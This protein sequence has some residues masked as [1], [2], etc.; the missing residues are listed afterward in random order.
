MFLLLD[1]LLLYI[2]P[3]VSDLCH[4]TGTI[5][6]YFLFLKGFKPNITVADNICNSILILF[7]YFFRLTMSLAVIM[8]EITNDIQVNLKLF[9]MAQL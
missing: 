6:I 8:V 7:Y 3:P 5:S 2:N 1:F 9:L 4:I